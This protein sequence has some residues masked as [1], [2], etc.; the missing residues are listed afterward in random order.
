[1]RK[2]RRLV[3]LF[4]GFETHDAEAQRLRFAYAAQKTGPLWDSSFDVGALSTSAGLCPE[5]HV[6]SRGA[7]W[8][9]QTDVVVCDWSDLLAQTGNESAIKRFLIGAW[10]LT[11]F[12]LN[13]TLFRYV[14]T[15][16]RYGL[17]FLYPGLLTFAALAPLALAVNGGAAALAGVVMSAGLLWLF[18]KKLHLL[19]MLD[20]WRFARAAALERD[21]GIADKTAFFGKALRKRIEV[22]HAENSD[23]EVLV[24]AHSLGAYFAAMALGGA[25]AQ[26][27]QDRPPP[28][29]M[30]AGSSL[31]KIALH[32]K[33]VRLRAAVGD[34]A[35][36]E[37][38]WLDVQSLTDVLN[39]YGADPA[40]ALGLAAKRPPVLQFVR[41][42]SM[43]TPDTYRRIKRNWL[44]VHRQFVLAGERRTSYSFHIMLAGPFQF[45]EIIESAG[46]P[47]GFVETPVIRDDRQ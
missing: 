8:E 41:F 16:W 34:I 15:S 23:G 24:A 26:T 29:L 13:G 17:F 6:A 46:L 31:L 18:S 21:A 4:A 1:M 11:S 32:P 14:R 39:F 9:A 22:F 33:A 19:T 30:M 40:A 44:R 27:K 47:R 45:A 5:F 3:F 12:A 35:R 20:N 37:A 42:R 7:G 38:P 28:G 43:L 2:I 10:A 36:S 25:L